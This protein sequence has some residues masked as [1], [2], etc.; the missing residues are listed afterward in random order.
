MQQ[1]LLAW[2]EIGAGSQVMS[3]L[4]EGVRNPWR[5]GV[6][7]EP[8]VREKIPLDPKDMG[9]VD[10]KLHKQVASRA[11]ENATCLDYV[12]PAFVV[13]QSSGKRRV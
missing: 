1:R 11:I 10:G 2:E 13:V 12:A 5:Q 9:W 7:M 8:F 3:W 4:G 6:P